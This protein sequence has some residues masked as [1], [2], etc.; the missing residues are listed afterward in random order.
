M[1][2]QKAIQKALA[3]LDRRIADL[4]EQAERYARNIEARNQIYNMLE[5]GDNPFKKDADGNYLYHSLLFDEDQAN[6]TPEEVRIME[7][8]SS[9]SGQKSAVQITIGNAEDAKRRTTE[10]LEVFEEH[11]ELLKSGRSSPEDVSTATSQNIGTNITIK[12]LSL[13]DLEMLTP[14]IDNPEEQLSAPD[15][16][17]APITLKR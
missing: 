6:Y 16:T 14:P 8:Q 11:K 2:A 10:E 7:T 9:I 13:D 17:A 5:N 15:L 3:D 12:E 1:E 4:R